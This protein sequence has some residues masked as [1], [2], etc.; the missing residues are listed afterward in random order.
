[1]WSSNS[2]ILEICDFQWSRAVAPAPG[3]KEAVCRRAQKEVLVIFSVS[4]GENVPYCLFKD[5]RP[6][7]HQIMAFHGQ[8]TEV[9]PH[10]AHNLVAA[11][12]DATTYILRTVQIGL[13][14]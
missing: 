14:F 7:R 8:G 5:K 10:K 12:P 3:E 6:C 13:F 11:F 9:P 1:M 4:L 2:E